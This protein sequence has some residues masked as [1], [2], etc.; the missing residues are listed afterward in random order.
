MTVSM[1]EMP[2]LDDP[3]RENKILST[4]DFFGIGE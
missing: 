3:K 4:K 1:P 2:T